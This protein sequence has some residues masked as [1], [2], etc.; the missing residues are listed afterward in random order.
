MNLSMELAI[1][2]LEDACRQQKEQLEQ[3]TKEAEIRGKVLNER[4]AVFILNGKNNLES[5]IREY[6]TAIAILKQHSEDYKRNEFSDP[7]QSCCPNQNCKSKNIKHRETYD[8][9][10]DCRRMFNGQH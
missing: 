7:K 8:Y 5:F 6:E 9:C 10:D 1:L 2:T 4:K 3:M